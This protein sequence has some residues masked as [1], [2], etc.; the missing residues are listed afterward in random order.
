MNHQIDLAFQRRLE[1]PPKVGEKVWT[2]TSS[3]DLRFSWQVEADAARS[4]I[5]IFNGYQIGRTRASVFSSN[6]IGAME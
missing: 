4:K 3:D 5:R 1:R 6:I 2:S